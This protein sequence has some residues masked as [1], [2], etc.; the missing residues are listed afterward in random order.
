MNF[1]DSDDLFIEGWRLKKKEKVARKLRVNCCS[2]GE[3]SFKL[4]PAPSERD[5]KHVFPANIRS[6]GRPY[7]STG[8]VVRT[9]DS[10]DR[11]ISIRYVR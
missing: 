10:V 6:T 3:G 11:G 4:A 8:V 7:T 2:S 9:G 5:I 1:V